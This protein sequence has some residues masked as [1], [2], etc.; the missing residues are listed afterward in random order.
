MSVVSVVV[1]HWHCWLNHFCKCNALTADMAFLHPFVIHQWTL[2][3][4]SIAPSMLVLCKDHCWWYITCIF[5]RSLLGLKWTW[6]ILHH[7]ATCMQWIEPTIL[8]L[9]RKMTSF[10]MHQNRMHFGPDISPVGRL[11]KATCDPLITS[12]R[13]WKIL[14][15]HVLVYF[16]LKSLCFHWRAF[17]PGFWVSCRTFCEWCLL[18]DIEKFANSVSYFRHSWIGTASFSRDPYLRTGIFY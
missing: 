10:R 2:S 7:H 3:E 14:S 8:T 13:W 5:Y 16:I 12:S 9:T 4:S 15:R 11:W 6:C 1:M 17:W 18:V